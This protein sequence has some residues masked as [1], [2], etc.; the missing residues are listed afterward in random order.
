MTRARHAG[1][2]AAQGGAARAEAGVAEPGRGR[3]GS[4]GAEAAQG[5]A[6]GAEAGV[7]EPGRGG[8]GSPGGGARARRARRGGR[9]RDACNT[10]G[11]TNT[12]ECY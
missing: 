5:G 6:T 3:G 12:P 7:A 10:P 4:P 9:A 11:S 1:A 2:E 8:G